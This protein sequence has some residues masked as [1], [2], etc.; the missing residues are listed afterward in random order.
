MLPASLE[1]EWK[2]HRKFENGFSSIK[3]SYLT[4]LFHTL[5]PINDTASSSVFTQGLRRGCVRAVSEISKIACVSG[6]YSETYSLL[7]SLQK[8]MRRGQVLIHSCRIN[9]NLGN[10]LCFPLYRILQ[11]KGHLPLSLNRHLSSIRK[12][13]IEENQEIFLE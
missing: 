6:N 5:R 3:S 1:T 10:L 9:G 8:K 13:V 4:I 2:E 12:V 11:K 7:R